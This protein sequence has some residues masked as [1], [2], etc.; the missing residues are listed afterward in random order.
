MI[1][2]DIKETP[3]EDEFSEPEEEEEIAVCGNFFVENKILI[4][5]PFLTV[6]HFA[7]SVFISGT[8]LLFV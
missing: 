8:F 3:Y 4:P 7:H 5:I 1:V 6:I 2:L